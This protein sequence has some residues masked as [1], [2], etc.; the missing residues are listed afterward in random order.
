MTFT[1]TSE[2]VAVRDAA[3][4][5]E[6]NLLISAL[7]GAAKTSTLVLIAEALPTTQIL[8]LAFNKKIADEMTSRLPKNCTAKTLNGLGHGVWGDAI[9]RRLSI[10]SSKTYDLLSAEM[11]ILDPGTRKEIG[12]NFTDI[13]RT[14]DFG[15]ACGW[16][17]DSFSKPPFK[18]SRLMNDNEFFGHLDEDYSAE[19][20][21]VITNI[22]LK[23][24][25]MAFAGECDFG[26]QILMPTVFHGAFPRF[27]LVLVDEAQDLSALNHAMLRKIVKK[28]VIAVGDPNQ[29]I[30]GFRGAHEESMDLLRKEFS[31]NEYM[32]TVSFR[33]P[34]AVVDA[35][36][37]RA[38]HM[39][40]P[41]WA[42][43]GSVTTLGAWTSDDIPDQSA[44]LC[45][46]NAPL[47]A[48]A[49][50]LL[51]AGRPAELYGN[52]I[53]KNLLKIMTKLGQKTDRI[54]EA[55][56]ALDRWHEKKKAA[57]KSTGHAALA[58]RV[59]CIRIFLSHGET[60]G[61]AMAYAQHLFNSRGPIKLM[62]VHKSKGLEFPHIL[63]LDE[64]LIG[65]KSQEPNIR[66]VAIT[67]AQETLTY[68]YSEE[69]VDT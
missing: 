55:Q 66:Y 60:L 56:E 15:K 30:Y 36:R 8:C 38:P 4:N 26:D 67:R 14:I 10:N 21:S 51:K 2:Q 59:A 5:D 16:I 41:E 58:D 11:D 53:G 57:T 33:C 61:D 9:G 23:S 24:L 45:R 18:A 7:A 19:V 44:V 46:N 69:Y 54:V 28:R 27:P 17:P 12:D 62:T 49:V 42:K 1:P 47:F 3:V 29:A 64:N 34:I 20:Q 22:T 13:L 6:A 63:I 32:L 43:P 48:T 37:W 50:R 31:M 52:D 39:K 65:D 35:A 25:N 68:I 40:A